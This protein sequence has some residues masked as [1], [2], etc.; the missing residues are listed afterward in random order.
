MLGTTSGIRE[1][2]AQD[3]P[4]EDGVKQFQPSL[5]IPIPRVSQVAF[6]SDDSTLTLCAAE[7]GGLAV[8]DVSAIKQG[9]K[10]PAF[11]ISTNGVAVRALVPNPAPE[12]AYL[13]ALVLEQGQL[14]IANLKER[15][16]DNGQSGSPLLRDGVSC[17]SWSNKGKQLTAGLGNGAAAQMT[18]AGETKAEIPQCPNLQGDLHGTCNVPAPPNQLLMYMNSIWNIM[19]RQRSLAVHLRPLTIRPQYGT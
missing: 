17:V 9:N 12:L 7:G 1:A 16:L 18:P 5:T 10:D 15:K 6:S 4:V 13:V 14:M 2:F 19:A 8:Y 3:G 11:Q